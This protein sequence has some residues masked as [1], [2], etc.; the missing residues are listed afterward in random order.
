MTLWGFIARLRHDVG[1]RGRFLHDPKAVLR[2][3]NVDPAPY[4]VPEQPTEAQL[5]HLIADWSKPP[6][7]PT[8]PL[9]PKQAPPAPA[10][11][12]VYGPPPGFFRRPV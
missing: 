4:E 10:P 9:P 2:E 12:P 11:T 8:D 5:N 1:L 6:A 3:F 7:P